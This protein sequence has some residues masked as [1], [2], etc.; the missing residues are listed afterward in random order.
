MTATPRNLALV[1]VV[2]AYLALFAILAGAMWDDHTGAHH[3]APHAHHA[4]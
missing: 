2:A 4:G 3:V 1:G